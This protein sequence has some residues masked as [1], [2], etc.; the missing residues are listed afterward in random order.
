MDDEEDKRGKKTRQSDRQLTDNPL[1]NHP[2]RKKMQ[3]TIAGIDDDK[4][5]DLM[6]SL[7]RQEKRMDKI[8]AKLSQLAEDLKISKEKNQAK[9]SEHRPKDDQDAAEDC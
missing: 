7:K 8:T 2:F 3:Y 5:R 6:G 9:T 4:I 1:D